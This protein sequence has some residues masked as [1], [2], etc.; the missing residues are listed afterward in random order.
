MTIKV[1]EINETVKEEK[2][3]PVDIKN[4]QKIFSKI[5]S[6][7]NTDHLKVEC[8]ACPNSILNDYKNHQK[9]FKLL[10]SFPEK[11]LKS[12]PI[13]LLIMNYSIIQNYYF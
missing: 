12:Y 1:F 3:S 7:E 8:K 10:L 5:F 9:K 13:M 4:I 6:P 11:F 2:L